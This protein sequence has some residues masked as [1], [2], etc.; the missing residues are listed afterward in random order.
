[1]LPIITTLNRVFANK[2]LKFIEEHQIDVIICSHLFAGE[3]VTRLK[4]AG[5]LDVPS[6]GIVTDYTI[7]PH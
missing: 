1:M 6:M 5:K 4:E 7:H 2:L 3:L